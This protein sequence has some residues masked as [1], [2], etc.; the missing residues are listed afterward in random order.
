VT[1]YGQLVLD[2]FSSSSVISGNG[3]YQNKSSYQLGVKY[4]NAFHVPNLMLQAEY[5]RVRLP[6][7]NT[8]VLSGNSNQALA[9]PWG[10]I[11]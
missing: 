10:M 4:Q 2:E 11:L 9:H 7:H 1:A 8:V 5:N 3:S 6:T